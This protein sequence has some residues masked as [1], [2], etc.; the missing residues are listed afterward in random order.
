MGAWG[1]GRQ[2]TGVSEYTGKGGAGL[3]LTQS[4]SISSALGEEKGETDT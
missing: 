4:W 2:E 1:E 3:G